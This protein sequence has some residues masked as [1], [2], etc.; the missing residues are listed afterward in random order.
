MTTYHVDLK[1]DLAAALSS[2]RLALDTAF[3]IEQDI[4]RGMLTAAEKAAHISTIET[5][6]NDG[7]SKLQGC[8]IDE[9]VGEEA[10]N[11]QISTLRIVISSPIAAGTSTTLQASADYA[12]YKGVTT[13][14]DIPLVV[15]WTSSDNA[16][17]SVNSSTGAA[18][19]E[20][21]GNVTITA[22][23]DDGT[24]SSVPMVVT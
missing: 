15:T 11:D 2:V 4:P 23:A 8:G 21:Q 9:Y 7:I 3:I 17:V 22:R 20:V 12:S 6:V 10:P 18:T 16:I 24:V 1:R 14:V 19:A 5:A 13:G